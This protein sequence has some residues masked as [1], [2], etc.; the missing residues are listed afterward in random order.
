M[1]TIIV[2]A[3]LAVIVGLVI[4]GMVLDKKNGRSC[5]GSCGS[6]KGCCHNGSDSCN[7]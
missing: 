2:G 1:G 4:R 5:G 7:H 6:C 3:V